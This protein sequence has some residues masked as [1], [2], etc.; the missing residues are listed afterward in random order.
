MNKGFAPKLALSDAALGL[1]RHAET[2]MPRAVL[3]A[4]PRRRIL[5]NSMG[6]ST[7]PA[8]WL[9]EAALIRLISVVEAYVDA[10]SMH[11]VGKLV[12]T[13]A[14]LVS[15]LV[16]EFEFASSGSWQDRHDAYRVYHG[17]SLRSLAGWGAIQAGI[18]VRNCL[19]HGLGYLTAKQR[20]Q[21]KL[22]AM[23]K[24]IDVTIG[25]S[26]MHLTAT[27]VPKVAAG[28]ILFVQN[29]DATISLT[30]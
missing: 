1:I 20:G 11:R 29:L 18:D 8:V 19:L 24:P 17:L 30:R 4:P 25:A 9:R 10:V 27:T 2:D 5:T 14:S 15:L 26:R 22:S 21:T 3:P 7:D 16:Q 12:D 28:C 13:R 23:V 6:A